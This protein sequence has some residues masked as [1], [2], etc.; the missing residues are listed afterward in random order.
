MCSALLKTP[1]KIPVI[2][3][4][5]VNL[6]LRRPAAQ[7]S[8]YK[9]KGYG[10]PSNAVDGNTDGDR[11]SK[12]CTHTKT[13]YEDNPW[14]RVDLGSSY[15]INRVDVYNRVDCCSNRLRNMEIRVGNV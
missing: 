8:P 14:W 3:E 7:S 11:V 1:N 13:P 2:S 4:V 9:F 10:E 6:A 15:L 12:S 5:P